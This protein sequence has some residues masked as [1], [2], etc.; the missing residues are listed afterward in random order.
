MSGVGLLFCIFT[1][2]FNFDQPTTEFFF[3]TP[4]ILPKNN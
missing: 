3:K 2:K 4:R 1:K